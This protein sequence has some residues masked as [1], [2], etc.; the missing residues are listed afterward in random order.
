MSSVERLKNF[1][2]DHNIHYDLL[3]HDPTYSTGELAHELDVSSKDIA[4]TVIIKNDKGYAMIVLRGDKKI[5]FNYLKNVFL[6]N[7]LE[8]ATELEIEKDR[9]IDWEKEPGGGGDR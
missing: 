2:D 4:K 9:E 6:S 8:L 3:H 5:N 7:K 1:L